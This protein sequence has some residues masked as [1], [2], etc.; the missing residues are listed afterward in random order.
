[1]WKLPRINAGVSM[2]SVND[3]RLKATACSACLL[4]QSERRVL[5]TFV[6]KALANPPPSVGGCCYK[7]ILT[8]APTAS[9]GG[10]GG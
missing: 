5:S 2:D 1:M 7:S 4:F 3:R 9:L 10:D 6:D 8:A